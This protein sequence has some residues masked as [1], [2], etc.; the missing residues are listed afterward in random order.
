MLSP[1]T[2]RRDSMKLKIASIRRGPKTAAFVFFGGAYRIGDTVVVT[3]AQA[4]ELLKNDGVFV[5]EKYL[6]SPVVKAA[7]ANKNKMLKP[8]RNKNGTASERPSDTE[9]SEGLSFDNLG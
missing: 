7:P 4:E 9:S 6:E 5:F 3:D 2:N 1:S 8:E